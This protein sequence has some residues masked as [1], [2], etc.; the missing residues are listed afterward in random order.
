MQVA[1]RE[2]GIA[3]NPAKT[4]SVAT[5]TFVATESSEKL[6][7]INSRRRGPML[8]DLTVDYLRTHGFPA[9]RA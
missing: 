4:Y 5:T 9:S 6:G 7:R 3:F 2:R 1:L 8:R